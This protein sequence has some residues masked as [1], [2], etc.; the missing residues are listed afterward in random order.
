MKNKFL[1]MFGMILFTIKIAFGQDIN[2]Q[3]L[4]IDE[5]NEPLIGARVSLKN[6]PTV[7]AST[8]FDG[9]FKLKATKGEIIIFSFIGYDTQEVP[10]SAD[11]KVQ[12]KPSSEL[13]DEVVVVGYA[14]KK[15]AATSASIVKVG[16]KDLTEKPTANIF[17]AVQGK[18]AGVQ[19]STSSGEPSAV[20]SVK[21]HGRGSINS[22]S[23]PLYI[24][25]GMPVSAGIIQGMNSN[26]FESMQFLKDAAATSIYG[27]RAANGVIY[28]T[29]KRGSMSEK[30]KINVRAQYGISSLANTSYYNRLQNTDETFQMLEEFGIKTGA[31]LDEMKKKYGMNNTKWYKYFYQNAPTY[32]ADVNVSGGMGRTNYF[33]SLGFFDQEGLRAGSSYN[34]LNTRLNLNSTLNDYIKLG[35][36]ASLFYSNT[37]TVPYPSNSFGGGFAPYIAPYYSPYDENGEEI[38]DRPIPAVFLFL[39]PKYVIDKNLYNTRDLVLNTIGSLTIT[40]FENFQIRSQVG[41]TLNYNIYNS[42][43]KPSYIKNEGHGS[44]TRSFNGGYSLSTNTVAE[45]KFNF[46]DIHHFSLLGGHEYTEFKA[47]GFGASGGGLVDDNLTL[48]SAATKDIRISENEYEYAFL[49]FFGQ[50]GYD[51]DDKYYVDLVLRNDAS[52]VFGANKRNGL[53]WSAGLLWKAKKESF[54]ENV[55]WIDDLDLRLSTGTQGNADIDYYESLALVGNYS[56]YNGIKGWGLVSPGNPD[57]GWEKQRKTTLG[58]SLDV[59]NRL[60]LKVELY[61]RL[62]SD[63][64][65][66]VP[67]PYTSG[68]ELSGQYAFVKKNVGKYQN[69]GIDL[70]ISADILSGKDYGL[71]AYFNFNYNKD[72]VI[73][74]FQGRDSWIIPNTGVGY[75]VGK[76]IMYVLPIFK[77]INPKNGYPRWYIPESE[78]GVFYPERTNKDETMLTSEHSDILDQNSGIARYAPF[79]GG[80]G[81]VANWKGFSLQADFAFFLGKHILSLDRYFLENPMKYAAQGFAQDRDVM[82]YWKKPLQN[83]KYPSLEYQRKYGEALSYDTRYLENASFM[84][85][86]NLTLG[87][88]IPKSL[89]EKQSALTG[90][91]IFLSG[92]N[93]LTFTKFQGQDPEDNSNASRGMN[94]NTK[95]FTLGVELNF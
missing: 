55:D 51:Y 1:M 4:V 14:S 63:M 41:V 17:D 68:L 31:E 21:L 32:Q 85:L 82:D 65:M 8:D 91:K 40:P 59:F 24:L 11:M 12:L 73:E 27:A 89:L 66:D 46:D 74:L 54:L 42:L 43:S 64:L 38:Y 19:V 36:N 30:A 2:V 28:V 16:S 69:R 76:P 90:A 5:N 20:A 53:F 67:Y 49:S 44:K 58:V 37:K 39:N 10:A 7:G 35:L 88:T 83:A 86:K 22:G 33:F 87:Y 9:K 81:L 79:S 52:S 6:N 23:A 95:Q 25:D 75:I 60:H 26:D 15:V 80:F 93:L 3:G 78:N 56:Q 45:Y 57:L 94:P 50:F 29:T 77:D 48:L 13:L 71:S 34:K 92:R 18:V 61:D 84:R 62:T 72:K 70:N 47:D